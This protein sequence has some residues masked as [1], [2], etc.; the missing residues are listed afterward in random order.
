MLELNTKL[1]HS[2]IL[3]RLNTIKKPQKHLTSKLGISRATFWRLSAGKDITMQTFLT[4]V[5][6]LEKE[7]TRYI[8]PKQNENTL[9]LHNRN[10]R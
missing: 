5:T 7:P 3:R 8:K 9:R 6:W 1:M 4:L 10:S 2:D